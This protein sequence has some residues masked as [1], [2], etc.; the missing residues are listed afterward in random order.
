MPESLKEFLDHEVAAKGYGNVSEY[1]RGL[2]REAQ[3]RDAK[4][5]LEAL[6]LEG[7]AG[8]NDIPLGKEFWARLTADAHK[9][10]ARPSKVTKKRAEK[11]L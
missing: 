8:G 9:I 10:K 7:L 3:E 4:A 1:I 6:L 5:R 11:I 2:L